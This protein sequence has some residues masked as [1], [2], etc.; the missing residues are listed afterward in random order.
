MKVRYF[1]VSLILLFAGS[2]ASAQCG[3]TACLTNFS[4]S[5]GTIVGDNSEFATGAV[6][7][8]VPPQNNPPVGLGIQIQV[9]PNSLSGSEF[10]CVGGQ[11]YGMGCWWPVTEG[12]NYLYFNFNASNY[13]ASTVTSGFTVSFDVTLTAY[14]NVTPTQSPQEPPSSDPDGPCP[15]CG[16]GGSPIN[17]L[18]GDTWIAQRDYSIPGLSGGLSLERTWNSLWPLMNPPEESGIFGDSWRSN[19]EE[20]IQ[21]LMD[22]TVKYWKGN[23]SS[24]VLHVH[25]KRRGVHHDRACR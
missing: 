2:L 3:V 5:P 7:L 9:T 22:G 6:Q 18:N 17:F 21:V 8:Y 11:G 15:G 14:Y 23:G 19:F 12:T 16:S 20:R 10:N 1:L 4:I 25:R 13:S 24:L